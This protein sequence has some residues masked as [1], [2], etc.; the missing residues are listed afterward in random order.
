MHVVHAVTTGIL[1]FWFPFHPSGL[2]DFCMPRPWDS[3]GRLHTNRTDP[4]IFDRGRTRVEDGGRWISFGWTYKP[5]E[6]ARDHVSMLCNPRNDRKGSQA[7]VE[8]T[9]RRPV[10]GEDPCVFDITLKLVKGLGSTG[11]VR[12]PSTRCMKTKQSGIRKPQVLVG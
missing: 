4:G 10:K 6:T 12:N 2:S 11:H 9:S 1:V 7:V 8:Q 3:V 5:Q